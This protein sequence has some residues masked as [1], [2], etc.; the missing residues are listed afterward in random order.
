MAGAGHQL[1][2]TAGCER[3]GTSRCSA[4]A[5]SHRSPAKGHLQLYS[6]VCNSCLNVAHPSAI[7]GVKDHACSLPPLHLA[8][9][10]S[11]QQ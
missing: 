5:H 6:V 10:Y 1:E 3:H 9:M 2:L 8:C 4:V 7:R 11:M